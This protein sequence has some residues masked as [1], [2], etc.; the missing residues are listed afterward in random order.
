MVTPRQI[1]AARALLGWSQQQLADRAIISVNA[2]A[3]LETGK[4]DSRASTIQAI[5]RA[6]TKAGIEFLPKGDRGEG[7]RMRRPT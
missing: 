1:R 5:E 6:L 7:V 3:R 4:A 2:L